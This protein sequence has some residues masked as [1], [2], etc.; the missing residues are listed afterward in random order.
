MFANGNPTSSCTR[1]DRGLIVPQA[2]P[3]AK[4]AKIEQDKQECSHD[5]EN[6]GILRPATNEDRNATDKDSTTSTLSALAKAK[7]AAEGWSKKFKGWSKKAQMLLNLH[8]S[9]FN[10]HRICERQLAPQYQGRSQRYGQRLD[11]VDM[12]ALAKAKIG[13]KG[14]KKKSEE[15]SRKAQKR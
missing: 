10:V 6:P 3:E 7:I 13:A 9:L 1:K 15:W 4:R 12:S 14:W 11:P 5:P 2:E 8:T